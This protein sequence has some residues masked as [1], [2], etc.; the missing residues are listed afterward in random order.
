[1][2]TDL[3]E[4]LLFDRHIHVT[5]DIPWNCRFPNICLYIGFWA[6]SKGKLW[7]IFDDFQWIL[8]N[9]HGISTIPWNYEISMVF[10][11]NVRTIFSAYFHVANGS[12]QIPWKASKSNIRKSTVRIICK[13]PWKA[14]KPNLN[15]HWKNWISKGYWVICNLLEYCS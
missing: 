9:N 15:P 11:Q 2:Y 10:W 13:I 8:L 12:A 7:V 1:M 3:S 5:Y 14:L 4:P 6:L